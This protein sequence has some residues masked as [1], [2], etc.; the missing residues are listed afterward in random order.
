MCFSFWETSSSRPSAPPLDPLACAVQKFPLKEPCASMV[1]ILHSV[2]W[3]AWTVDCLEE[4]ALSLIGCRSDAV[5]DV[6]GL[7]TYGPPSSSDQPA[8]ACP[9]T[10]ALGLQLEAMCDGLPECYVSNQLLQ[11]TRDQ[12]PGVSAVLVDV[13]CKPNGTTDRAL[14]TFNRKSVELYL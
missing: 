12:C 14:S 4:A 3:F 1:R 11:L 2:C 6:T 8:T 13:D 9:Y 5:L 10:T 7:T